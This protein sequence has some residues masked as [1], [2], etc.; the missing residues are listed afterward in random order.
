[1]SDYAAAPI[2]PIVQGLLTVDAVTNVPTFS[3]RGV[4]DVARVSAGVFDLTLDEGL[5]GNGGEIDPDKAR[6]LV[7]VR[8]SATATPANATSIT[9][10]GVTYQTPGA[11]GGMTV[12]RL[13][14]T[15]DGTPRVATDPNGVNAG[16]AEVVVFKDPEVT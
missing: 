8:G 7:T 4:S 10:V 6:S 13:V 2:Q 12:V 1:M 16:G 3:G 15:V 9:S 14:F 5:I 11:D